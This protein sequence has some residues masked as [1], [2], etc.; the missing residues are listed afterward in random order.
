MMSG[1]NEPKQ[2]RKRTSKRI[3]PVGFYLGD[4]PAR[5]YRKRAL[6]LIAKQLGCSGRSE[7]LQKIADGD[8]VVVVGK[9][10]E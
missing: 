4:S 9:G 3:S 8:L 10:S 1:M 6:D 5:D 2:P 7:M